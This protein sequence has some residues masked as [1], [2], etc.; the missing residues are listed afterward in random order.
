MKK[1]FAFQ[2]DCFLLNISAHFI[3]F[4]CQGFLSQD[5]GEGGGE[6]HIIALY[7][8]IPLRKI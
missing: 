4:L 7:H 6:H 1:D 3:L 5:T 2:Y 8:F